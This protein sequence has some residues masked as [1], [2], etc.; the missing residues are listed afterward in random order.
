MDDI[1]GNSL[2]T[3]KIS[4]Q[5]DDRNL[6][7]LILCGYGKNGIPS[8]II[9]VS[10]G[11]NLLGTVKFTPHLITIGSEVAKS[12][13][14]DLQQVKLSAIKRFEEQNWLDKI[15]TKND[16]DYMFNEYLDSL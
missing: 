8:T 6:D 13:F 10:E 11:K 14:V 12:G 16:S 9:T 5:K 3:E 7:L 2:P 1:S 15:L 4:L